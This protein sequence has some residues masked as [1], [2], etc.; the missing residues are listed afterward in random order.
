[1]SRE[2]VIRYC[3]EY[4]ATNNVSNIDKEFLRTAKEALQ[5]EVKVYE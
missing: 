2:D 1:M 3:E 5:K 4:L